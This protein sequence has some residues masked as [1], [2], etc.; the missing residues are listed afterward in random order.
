MSEIC[1]NWS[2]W[3]KKTRF[4]YMDENQL[5][6]T[7]N[8]LGAVR[9]IVL[10]NAEI[11]PDDKVIDIGT[12]TGLLA[13]GV[14]EKLNENGKIIFS[15]KFEDCL[16]ECQNLIKTLEIKP[17]VEFLQ[18]DSTDIKLESES[19]DKALMRSVLVHILD[20]QKAF[21]E[22]YR[23]LNPGG[24]FA[25]FEPIMRSNTKY[26]E[27]VNPNAITDYEGFKQAEEDFMT[28][29]NDPITNFD[30]NSI[31]QNMEI[32]GFKDGFVNVEPSASTYIVAPN[33]VSTWFNTPPSPGETTIKEKFLKYFD[34]NKV[35]KFIQE[36]DKDLTGREIT[37]TTNV[38][39]IKGIK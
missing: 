33:T 25:A 37:V 1:K 32:A 34:E 19:V 31:A 12:G 11:K 7:M 8:W 30:A 27:I 26:Y 35:D 6:Q 39:F 24:I 4:S 23:I 3:L 14:M 16:I 21:N 18:S 36:V 20:K 28:N 13:F 29:S 10:T 22:V 5:T 17:K 38:A 9:D 15:D 2:E